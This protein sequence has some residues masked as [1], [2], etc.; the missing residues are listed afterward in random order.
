MADS[1]PFVL[2]VAIVWGIVAV[3]LLESPVRGWWHRRAPDREA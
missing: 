3:A 1:A 2:A